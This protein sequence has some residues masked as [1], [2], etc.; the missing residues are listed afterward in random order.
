MASKKIVFRGAHK[1]FRQISLAFLLISIVSAS[2]VPAA[3][4]TTRP[5]APPLK[6]RLFYGGNVNLQFGTYTDSLPEPFLPEEG[7]DN[8]W[9]SGRP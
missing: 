5:E 6:D 7:S 3:G 9:V 4:Q 2:W 8:S 1:S